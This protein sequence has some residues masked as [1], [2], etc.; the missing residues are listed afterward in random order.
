MQEA[1]EHR[2]FKTSLAIGELQELETNVTNPTEYLA[3][4]NKDTMYFDQAIRKPDAH[5]FV[6]TIIKEINDHIQRKRW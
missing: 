4:M 2:A 5:H 6:D 3:T 1:I